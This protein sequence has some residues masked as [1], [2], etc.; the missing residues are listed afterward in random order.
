M[1]N[2]DLYYRGA[3]P[4][5][6]GPMHEVSL[7]KLL[8]FRRVS[9]EKLRQARAVRNSG[10]PLGSTADGQKSCLTVPKDPELITGY[11]SLWAM[12]G[13]LSFSRMYYTDNPEPQTQSP[14]C[15][16]TAEVISPKTHISLTL[17]RK[18]PI[19]SFRTKGP[20]KAG[21]S[22]GLR[23]LYPDVL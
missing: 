22:F 9:V 17:N 14:Q 5:E 7:R 3:S 15:R 1:G 19:R 4:R 12:Q 10:T 8:C 21:W 6:S 20:S 23:V 2:Q 11:S 16:R 18:A 13:I